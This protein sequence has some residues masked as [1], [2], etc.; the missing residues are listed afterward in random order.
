MVAVS[1]MSPELRQ[2]FAQV[3]AFTYQ[4]EKTCRPEKQG[5]SA[6]QLC[7]LGQLQGSS[8]KAFPPAPE[9]SLAELKS[10]VK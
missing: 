5:A 10:L 8:E 2:T 7:I 3:S 9:S 4:N 1:G 6:L